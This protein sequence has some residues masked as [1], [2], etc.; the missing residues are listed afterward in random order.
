M[1][2]NITVDRETA[3]QE[4]ERWSKA[5]RIGRKMRHANAKDIEEFEEKKLQVIDMMEDAKLAFNSDDS[6]LTYVFEFPEDARNLTEIK[7][8]RPKG[9][10]LVEGD[11]FE[12]KQ[13]VHKAQAF[14]CQMTGKDM[15]FFS[16]L[17]Y[18]DLES[19]YTVMNLFL[20]S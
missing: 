20:A 5:W 19:L 4:F 18:I 3:I 10:A 17:D 8:S 13:S 7:I 6:S 16:K 1:E 14:L 9:A 2:N 15:A 11:K 12:E